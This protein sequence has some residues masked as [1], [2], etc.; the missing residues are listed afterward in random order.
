MALG[1]T[2]SLLVR[3]DPK[4]SALTFNEPDAYHGA[5]DF[6]Q[7]IMGVQPAFEADAQLGNSCKPGMSALNNPTMSAQF[8]A[9]FHT[10]SGNARLD[11]AS[12]QIGTAPT[13]VVPFVS[14][15][16]HR[17]ARRP[18]WQAGY[19]R[20]HIQSRFEDHRIMRIRAA[21][22]HS[23]RYALSIYNEMAFAAELAS[24]SR[25]WAR[26]L[27]PRGLATVAPSMLQRLQSI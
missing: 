9:A 2:Y 20:H 22:G 8:F 5:C 16:L 1:R 18:P 24:V 6:E 4:T 7:R 10:A 26:F 12:A 23:Q 19:R 27:T 15:Q 14:M 11:A 13:V 25:I 17:S 3:T 21:H